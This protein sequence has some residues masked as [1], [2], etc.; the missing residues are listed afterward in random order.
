MESEYC[1][2]FENV[3]NYTNQII[4]PTTC[5][6]DYEIALR[7]ALKI[8]F[9]NANF[10]GDAFHFYQANMKWIRSHNGSQLVTDLIKDLKILVSSSTELE[11]VANLTTFLNQWKT[12]HAPYE[13]YFQSTWLNLH[14]PSVWAEYKIGQSKGT[15]SM[16]GWHNRLKIQF[17][18]ST[19]IDFAVKNLEQEVNYYQL[20]CENEHLYNS[21]SHEVQE[22]QKYKRRKTLKNLSNPLLVEELNSQR[23]VEFS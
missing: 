6:A 14:P 3:K 20:I 18:N 9:P 5:S 8:K 2:F 12:K 23:G 7:N 21:K 13:E 1:W 11:F 17:P 15:N 10:S 16:E 4:N 22:K 19:T